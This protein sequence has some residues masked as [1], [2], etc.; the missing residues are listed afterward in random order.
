MFGLPHILV[1]ASKI[2]DMFDIEC[3]PIRVLF[4][5]LYKLL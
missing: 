3:Q 2:L 4:G 5:Q 1:E